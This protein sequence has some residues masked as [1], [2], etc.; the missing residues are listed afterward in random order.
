MASEEGAAR[1]PLGEI[2]E[3]LGPAD[4][5]RPKSESMLEAI[6]DLREMLGSSEPLDAL[7][8]GWPPEPTLRRPRDD[9]S[10]YVL[11]PGV[12]HRLRGKSDLAI[13]I[14]DDDEGEEGR[15]QERR[16]ACEYDLLRITPRS[17]VCSSVTKLTRGE[18][19]LA[20]ARRWVFELAGERIVLESSVE[21]EG[22]DPKG[23]TDFARKL[24]A[25]IAQ[26]RHQAG[27]N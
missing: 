8:L 1:D 3:L 12:V 15:E 22:E 19:T 27:R 21:R 9:L 26:S 17:R 23:V 7:L 24:A 20:L 14:E 10:V 16:S 2:E 5:Q 18:D 13:E 6:C 25:Q 4:K 11:A